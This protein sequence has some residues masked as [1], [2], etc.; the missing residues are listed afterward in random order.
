MAKYTEFG[1]DIGSG[2]SF[3]LPNYYALCEEIVNAL[4]EHTTL[5]KKHFARLTD[6]C[7]KDESL[8]LLAFDLMYCCKAYN[9]YNG[10]VEPVTRK[11]IKKKIQPEVSTEELAR[12]EAERLEKI[13]AIQAEIS[14]LEN[15]SSEYADISLID[16]QVEF[17]PYGTGVVVEQNIDKITVR[18]ADAEKKFMLNSKYKV[19]PKFENDDEIVSAFTE[20]A[21]IMAKIQKLRSQLDRYL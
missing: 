16:V 4:K 18:F 10:L 11:T 13:N 3:S 2:T 6:K 7:F 1:L 19:R 12:L 5:L 9:F 17:K 21:D 15:A 14:N 20:Y 8:H